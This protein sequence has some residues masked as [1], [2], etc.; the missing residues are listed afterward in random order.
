LGT[1]FLQPGSHRATG[2]GEPAISDDTDRRLAALIAERK[3]PV[4]SEPVRA[5]D[6]TFH[7]G[8]TLHSAGANR[9]DRVREVFTV[10]YFAAGTR[11]SQPPTTINES[12]LRFSFSAS[13]P[14]RRQR[15]S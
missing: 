12:T 14:A 5:G 7:S 4:W 3:W 9:S 11:A 8:G 1:R 2:L 10:I 13:V 15:A 6:A